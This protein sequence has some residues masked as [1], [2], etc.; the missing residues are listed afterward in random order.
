MSKILVST[1]AH[2]DECLEAIKQSSIVVFD[3][4][5]NGLRLYTDHW[6]VGIAFYCDF[7]G[8]S[9]YIPFGHG[10]GVF[11][12]TTNTKVNQR[13]VVG[14][15]ER[16]AGLLI[17]HEQWFKR[18]IM[19][20]LKPILT[21][22][23]TY[24]CHNAQFDLTALLRAGIDLAG[25]V[26]YDT[27]LAARTL[28][29]DFNRSYF[30][31]P[32]TGE[33]EQGNNTLKWQSRLFGLVE[34]KDGLVGNEKQLKEAMQYLKTALGKNILNLDIKKHMWALSPEDVYEYA[35][36]DVEL[37]Y[38]L[39]G[40]LLGHLDDWQQTEV[41][42]LMCEHQVNIAW[43]MNRTGFLID[44]ERGSELMAEYE[45][46]RASLL[47]GTDF[48]INS[49]PQIAAFAFENFNMTLPK[50]PKG[51]P[52]TDK[53]TL[54]SYQAKIGIFKN[55]LAARA[56]DKNVGTYIK[57]W[58]ENTTPTEP[59]HFN[60]NVLGTVTG[61][62]S[63]NGQQTPKDTKLKY[64]PKK[65]LLPIDPKKQ[66][67][68]IDYSQLEMRVGAWVAETI[69]GQ[70]QDMTLTN[71]I[72]D[73]VDMHAYTRDFAGVCEILLQGRSVDEFMT[74][75]L[76]HDPNQY[77]NERDLNDAFMAHARDVAKVPN[78]A[79]MY[80]GG[81][82][83]LTN[84]LDGITEQ[85][86][87]DIMEG[88]KAAYPT[89]VR[90]MTVLS[91]VAMKWRPNPGYFTNGGKRVP[92]QYIQYPDLCV[93]FIRK[94]SYYS[95]REK[96]EKSKDAFNSIVQGTAG[97]ITVESINRV[98]AFYTCLDVHAQ[99]HDSLVYSDFPD[100]QG[101]IPRI[102]EIMTDWDIVPG[103]EC[104]VEIAPVG[105]AWGYKE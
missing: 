5:T 34:M 96:S 92:Y 11:E 103:L 1:E 48:N 31:M 71:L 17:H 72:L 80:G 19:Y 47:E 67:V 23:R 70:G 59:L 14:T 28:Y 90:A 68:E 36:M 76:S 77:A 30:R 73:G 8:N 9:Y 15:N 27:M 78:F 86:A 12:G 56:L 18:Y 52:K 33:R 40:V 93:P 91:N 104:D 82:E 22:D 55:V 54:K 62:W 6:M 42:E 95:E 101:N 13:K 10:Q 50:T 69:V 49:A 58:L 88:W 84:I 3:T 94:W 32:D 38:Q 81:W 97:F 75:E 105:A 29:S 65:L 79:A 61:R 37:T 24:L 46:E 63:S 60:F 64:S 7:N 89:V 102:V 57:K 26:V 21:P 20:R 43:R 53:K 4:E 74:G 85:Q 87:R 35:C 51:N 39:H 45:K 41:Y 16:Y 2:L 25:A 44:H 100:N 99:I 83:A 66:I 98:L